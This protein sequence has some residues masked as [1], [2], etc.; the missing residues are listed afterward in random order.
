MTK[1]YK[2]SDFELMKSLA[3]FYGHV[4]KALRIIFYWLV[5]LL[6]TKFVRWLI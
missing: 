4:N 5:S 2:Q 3:L 6:V 1:H